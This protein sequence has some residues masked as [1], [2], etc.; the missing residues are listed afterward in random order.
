MGRGSLE[1]DVEE[2]VWASGRKREPGRSCQGPPPILDGCYARGD[3]HGLDT[4]V[5]AT[6]AVTALGS[7]KLW[8]VQLPVAAASP[9][10]RRCLLHL[11]LP[12]PTD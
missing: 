7:E 8:P 3:L 9:N 2:W 1:L 6:P 11:P 12:R 4:A 10:T 5:L